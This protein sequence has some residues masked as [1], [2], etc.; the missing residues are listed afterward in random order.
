MA[1]YQ[2]GGIWWYEFQFLGQRIRESSYSSSKKLAQRIERERRR[3]MELGT[4][5][6]KQTKQPLLFSVAARDWLETNRA[7][8]S[9]SNTRIEGYNVKHL[10]PFFGKLLLTDISADDISRY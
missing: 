7:H 8:W 2:R 5:G 1:V 6:L 9:A 3:S 4:V 10:L